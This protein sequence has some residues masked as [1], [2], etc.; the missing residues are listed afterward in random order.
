MEQHLVHAN[1]FTYR[2]NKK[3]TYE[4]ILNQQTLCH[5]ISIM[6]IKVTTHYIRHN[7]TYDSLTRA[8][9][10]PFKLTVVSPKPSVHGFGSRDSM[11]S[12]VC[13][14]LTTT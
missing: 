13:A 9:L 5:I 10:A 12:K 1:I 8:T 14:S 7:H 4:R 3:A 11:R 6:K 2:L